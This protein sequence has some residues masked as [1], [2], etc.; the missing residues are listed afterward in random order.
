MPEP[1]EIRFAVGYPDGLRSSIW[2]G[3]S[4]KNDVFLSVRKIA[5]IIKLSFHDSGICAYGLTKQQEEQMIKESI[6]TPKDRLPD[7]WK[8]RPTPHFGL[9]QVAQIIIPSALLE[10]KGDVPDKPIKWLVPGS[11]SEATCINAFFANGHL[12]KI[13]DQLKNKRPEKLELIDHVLLP[14][15]EHFLLIGLI[16][17][18]D[19]QEF[20]EK[21]KNLSGPGIPF[22][23]DQNIPKN[24]RGIF[25]VNDPKKDR[26]IRLVDCAGF[27]VTKN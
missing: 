16:S 18:F 7:R 8:R 6:K 3:W 20:V 27:T 24:P 26:F 19:A 10:L 23:S 12:D 21:N 15:G 25:T 22:A 14:K 5:G 1:L 11:K 2:R 13:L 9:S 4:N 17:S